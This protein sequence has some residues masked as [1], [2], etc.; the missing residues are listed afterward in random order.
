MG[1]KDFCDSWLK[2][3]F[4]LSLLQHEQKKKCWSETSEKSSERTPQ[5]L[6]YKIISHLSDLNIWMRD[7]KILSD[8]K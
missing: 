4:F 6:Q 5:H 3:S 7:K 8:Y 1:Q 2:C